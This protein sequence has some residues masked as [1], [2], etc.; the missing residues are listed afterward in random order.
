MRLALHSIA[1]GVA[2]LALA[3]A[4]SDA[5]TTSAPTR[6]FSF[7]PEYDPQAA[8]WLGWSEDSSQHATQVEMIRALLPNIPVRLM[9]RSEKD[10]AEAVRML[11]RAGI[12]TARVSFISHPLSTNWIRDSGPRFLSDG[13]SLEVADFAWN[14]YGYPSEIRAGFGA[15]VMGRGVIDND[16]ANEMKLP[17]VTSAIVSEGGALDVS[18]DVML[19]YRQTAMERNPGVPF[20]EIEREYLRLYGKKKIVW[21]TRAPLSDRVFSGPKIANYFGWGANGHVDEFARFIDDETI[22]IAQLD[23]ADAASNPLSEA[24]SEILAENLAELRKATNVGGKPFRIVTFPVPG[25][26]YYLRKGTIDDGDKKMDAFGAWYRSLKIGDPINWV[27]AVSY[28]NFV[29]SNGVV[30]AP[31]YWHEGIPES[32]KAKDER[33]RSLLRQLFPGRDIVQINP[34]AFNWSGGGMHCSTQQQPAVAGSTAKR[35]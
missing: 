1:A 25:V 2:A 16:I 27:P 3:A 34:M 4:S 19:A 28:L 13:K 15:E 33:A 22:A 18:H 7:P 23:P 35:R 21:M 11:S 14:G 24:D 9:V 29:I 10:R 30:L 5:R 8:M 17:V 6:H 31:T 12:D 26:Q 20:D 32:E